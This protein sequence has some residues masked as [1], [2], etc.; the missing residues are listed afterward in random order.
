VA[1][2]LGAMNLRGK[3]TLIATDGNT[4]NVH[5]SARN[6]PG[7]TVSHVSDL[8]AWSILRPQ[9]ILITLSAI[10]AMKESQPATPASDR[11]EG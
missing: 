3:T 4:K 10:N 9:Q 1:A 5:R 2:M 6:I 8:N 11:D 7:V